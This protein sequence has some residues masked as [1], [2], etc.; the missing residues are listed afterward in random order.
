M[1]YRADFKLMPARFVQAPDHACPK[2]GGSGSYPVQSSPDDYE[3]VE[4]E[5]RER[6][7]LNNIPGFPGK[8]PMDLTNLGGVKRREHI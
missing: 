1:R 2:C 6:E 7:S 5:C 8:L 3:W 4:C